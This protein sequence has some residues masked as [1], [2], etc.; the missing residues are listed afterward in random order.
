M[1]STSESPKKK[2]STGKKVLIGFGILVLI[3]LIG[4]QLDKKGSTDSINS[5]ANTALTPAQKD[6][7]EKAKQ[8]EIKKNTI[9][10]KQLVAEYEANEVS[11]DNAFKGKTFY[12]TG[13]VAD[14]KKD[15]VNKIY[16]IL[17][18]ENIIRRVQCYFDDAETAGKLSKG[19]S[20]TFKGKCS[21]L[22]M[23]VLMK[24]CELVAAE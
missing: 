1:E 4:S 5:E 11:A 22:M 15:I 12:V 14:I 13:T 8:E 10:A 23:N 6:S 9:S 18:G 7:L 3:G 16:V 20:V 2:M 17:E 24:D 21:G 19:M